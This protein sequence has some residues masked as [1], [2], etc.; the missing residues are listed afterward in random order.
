MNR[1]D[2]TILD[3]VHAARDITDFVTGTSE[4]AFVVDRLVSSA[5]LRKLEV[6]GEATKRLSESFRAT[7]GQLPWKEMAGLRDRLIHAY[8]D[9]DLHR[10]WRIATAD[11]PAMLAQLAPLVPPKSGE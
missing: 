11:V 3:I 8:D 6:I 4:D 1:D 5:V 7:H 10:V 2:A 9:V